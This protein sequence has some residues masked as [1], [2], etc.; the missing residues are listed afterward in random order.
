MNLY[1]SA[2]LKKRAGLVLT[3]AEATVLFE[4]ENG[5]GS[6]FVTGVCV[7]SDG[8]CFAVSPEHYHRD[9]EGLFDNVE[10]GQSSTARVIGVEEL[11][12]QEQIV[13]NESNNKHI[14]KG[15]FLNFDSACHHSTDPKIYVDADDSY[16]IALFK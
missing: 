10:S 1:E 15:V 12:E 16:F 9:Y 13:I 4:A 3:E 11:P 6:E 8:E 5:G 2:K 7:D 14:A